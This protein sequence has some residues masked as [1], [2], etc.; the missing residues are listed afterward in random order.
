M[1]IRSGSVARGRNVTPGPLSQVI[2]T[3]LNDAF[4]ELL[5]SQESF[6]ERVGIPQST[7]SAYL[8]GEKVLNLETFVMLC[9]ALGLDPV[10]VLATALTFDPEQG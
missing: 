7:L 6:G 10:N 1:A 4:L 3:I 5:T 9:M 8:R 2:A